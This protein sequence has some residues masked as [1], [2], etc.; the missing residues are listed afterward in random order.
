MLINLIINIII[1]IIIVGTFPVV[2]MILL[3][4]G[5]LYISNV[6]FKNKGRPKIDLVI[7][8]IYSINATPICH[9]PHLLSSSALHLSVVIENCDTHALFLC[10]QLHTTDSQQMVHPFITAPHKLKSLYF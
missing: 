1:I 10:F 4:P 7:M 8:N 3:Y 9:R 6:A 2:K 5:D